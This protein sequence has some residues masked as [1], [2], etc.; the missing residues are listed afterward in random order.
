MDTD[1][2]LRRLAALDIGEEDLDEAVH[3]AASEEA[4]ATNNAGW[5]AQVEYLI[6][7]QGWGHEDILNWV[8]SRRRT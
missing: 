1:E 8:K 7:R 4:S 3:A 5:K 2:L 6:A